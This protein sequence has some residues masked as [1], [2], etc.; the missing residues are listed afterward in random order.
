MS[1]RDHRGQIIYIIEG[2]WGRKNDQMSIYKTNGERLMT[3]KQLKLSP[4]PIFELFEGNEKTGTMRKH[5]GLFG[6]RD[7]YFTLHP[8]KWVITGDFEDLYF[9]THKEN[10]LIMECNKDLSN[11]MTVYELLVKYENDAVLSALITTIF[12][13]Y[14]RKKVEDEETEDMSNANYKLGFFNP[15]S[16]SFSKSNRYPLKKCIKT[17]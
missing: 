2:R 6:L 8:Q 5:P 12:D 4:I 10:E 13:H 11:G 3:M 17:R 15:F 14:S 16:L 1:V 9:T 7:S